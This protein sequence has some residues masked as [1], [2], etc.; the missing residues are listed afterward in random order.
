VGQR[1]AEEL[2]DWGVRH[3]GITPN[4]NEDAMDLIDCESEE[5]HNQ[6]IDM[7]WMETDSCLHQA[8]ETPTAG[9][10]PPPSPLKTAVGHGS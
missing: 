5:I 8:K 9:T 2:E 4:K 6:I 1:R 10:A 3:E 7:E